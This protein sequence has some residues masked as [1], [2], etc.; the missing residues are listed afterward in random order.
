MGKTLDSLASFRPISLTLCVSKLFECIILSRLLFFLK[1]NSILFLP[2]RPDSALEGLLSITFGSLLSP[3]RM[4][5]RALRRSFLLLISLKLLTLSVIP[6]FSTNSFR[7][8]SLLALLD[9]LNLSFLKGALAWFIT[10]TKVISFE[11]VKV[12]RKDLFLALYFPICS[13]MICL[14]P[15]LFS[16]PALF[17]LTIWPFGPPPPRSLLRWS[18]MIIVAFFYIFLKSS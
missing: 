5:F 8:A 10:I 7:L 1:S 9:G 17:M 13:S 16:S 14:L 15:S 3:F 18:W 4:G 11:A 6:P 2:A 12:F